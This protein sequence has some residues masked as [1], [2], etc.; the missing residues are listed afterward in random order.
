LIIARSVPSVVFESAT[1][2]YLLGSTGNLH[3][4]PV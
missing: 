1:H 3:S 2:L 4:L